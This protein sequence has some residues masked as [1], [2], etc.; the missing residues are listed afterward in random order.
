MRI[1]GSVTFSLTKDNWHFDYTVA[2]TSGT[3][4]FYSIALHE[5]GRC[6]GQATSGGVWGSRSTVGSS[7]EVRRCRH[8]KMIMGR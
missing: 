1:G 5:L 3:T 8:I 7:R 6:F 4:D 2:G